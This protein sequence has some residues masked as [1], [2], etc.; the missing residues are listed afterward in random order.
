MFTYPLPVKSFGQPY[1]TPDPAPP[2]PS[3]RP[4]AS[5]GRGPNGV[6]II[7][8]Y[9]FLLGLVI[10]GLVGYVVIKHWKMCRQR[11]ANAGENETDSGIV[12]K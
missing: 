2:S 12:K 5:G 11:K 8:I 3:A 6:D 7:P 10:V 9:C 4:A 1:P